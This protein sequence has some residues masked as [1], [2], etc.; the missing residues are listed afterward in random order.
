[1]SSEQGCD[2]FEAA[3]AER[4]EVV[5]VRD[6]GSVGPGIYPLDSDVFK[7]LGGCTIDPRW[8]TIGAFESPPNER[9][10]SWVYVTSGLSN[11]W[12]E[13]GPDPDRWSGLGI[14]LLIQCKFQSEWALALIRNLAAYQLMLATGQFGEREPLDFWDRTGIGAPIDFEQSLLK[15]LLFVPAPSFGGARQLSSGRFEYLQAVGMTAEEHAFGRDHGYDS[16]H[17]LLLS[18][19]VSP[20]IDSARAS[21]V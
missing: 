1:M 10:D 21:V 20:V 6:F 7:R 12:E 14:E 16:L 11:A 13:D 2:W 4:E 9:R 15:A 19:G 17:E 3:W 5:Y 18:K 8:L